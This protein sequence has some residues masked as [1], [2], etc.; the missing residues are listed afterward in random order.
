MKKLVL[1]FFIVVWVVMLS[2]SCAAERKAWS[3]AASY[4][5]PQTLGGYWDVTMQTGQ[6]FYHIK[7]IYWGTDDDTAVFQM[8]DGTLVCQSGACVCVE[9]KSTR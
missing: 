5:D 7:C 8:D 9:S 3:Q 6:T 4:K 2:V 1:V